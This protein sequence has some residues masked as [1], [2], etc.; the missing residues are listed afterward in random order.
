MIYRSFGKTGLDVPVLSAGFMRAMQSW[1]KDPEIEIT[2]ENQRNFA[3]VVSAA[4]E[5]GMH[6]FETAHDY[7]TSER[8]LG[9]ALRDIPRHSFI[10][11]TKVQ[12]GPDP[13]KFIRDFEFSLQ[14]LQVE[15]V[16]LLAIHGINDYRSLWH[17]CREG[18]CLAAARSLQKQ[19][20]IGAVG[21]SGHGPADVISAAI[22]YAGDGGFDY[23]NLHWYYIYQINGRVQGEAAGKGLGVFI[24]SPTDK[25]GQ[26]QDPPDSFRRLCSPFE[27]LI[28]NDVYCLSRPGVHTISVG[29]S[30]PSDFATHVEA[31]DHLGA[32]DV[33]AQIDEQCRQAMTAATG[34]PRPEG[35]WDRL[36]SWDRTPGLINIPF[37]LWLYNLSRGWGMTAYSRRRYRQLGNDVKWVPGNNGASA[38]KHN[39]QSV[40]E[41][42]GLQADELVALLTDAHQL[43]GIDG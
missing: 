2:P 39:L 35:L 22:R 16:D 12:P 30:K 43:L 33:V 24:I 26:L 34:F 5:N 9:I 32:T 13:R 27:P 29:A 3:D 41:N 7:G 17:T 15:R 40:A 10:L 18:G 28:F 8:Q 20:K 6:H 11:Q 25:G 42:A 19:G 4:L 1:Q 23:V 14:R 37:I 21:F 36:P 38:G 31:L